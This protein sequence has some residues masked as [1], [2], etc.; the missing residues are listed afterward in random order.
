MRFFTIGFLETCGEKITMTHISIRLF[1]N[2][3]ITTQTRNFQSQKCKKFSKTLYHGNLQ[4][5]PCVNFTYDTL[6]NNTTF[7]FFIISVMKQNQ[8]CLFA[9]HL[10]NLNHLKIHHQ[11]YPY[12]LKL[13]NLHDQ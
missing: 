6:K 13:L 12:L 7:H 5:L 4:N 10:Q 1:E 11:A 2:K 3:S 9:L 8:L